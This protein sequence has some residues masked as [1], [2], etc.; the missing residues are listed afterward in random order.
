MSDM[1]TKL[2]LKAASGDKSI[3]ILGDIAKMNKKAVEYAKNPALSVIG[4]AAARDDAAFFNH[5]ADSVGSIS[6]SPRRTAAQ[7]FRD[8][9]YTKPSYLDVLKN[10]ANDAWD[11]TKGKWNELGPETRN[12]IGAVGLGTAGGLAGDA[13]IRLLGGKR[14]K[15]LRLLGMLGGVGAGMAANSYLQNPDFKTKVDTGLSSLISKL[16]A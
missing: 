4:D 5:T 13:L 3:T 1:K 8:A 2:L 15:A 14:S 6:A 7:E 16:K 12:T 9:L 10:R 11:W